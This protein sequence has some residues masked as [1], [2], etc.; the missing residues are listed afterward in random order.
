MI[1]LAGIRDQSLAS[2]GLEGRQLADFAREYYAD[3]VGGRSYAVPDDLEHVLSVG[4]ATPAE[5]RGIR[6]ALFAENILAVA[7]AIGE[8]F[9]GLYERWKYSPDYT[10]TNY[11]LNGPPEGGGQASYP[12]ILDALVELLASAD[13]LHGY[14]GGKGALDGEQGFSR[15]GIMAV[16]ID[17]ADA[18]NDLFLTGVS[19]GLME[20]VHDII[21]DRP[22]TQEAAARFLDALPEY[23]QDRRMSLE[24]FLRHYRLGQ[25]IRWRDEGIYSPLLQRYLRRHGS[26]WRGAFLSAAGGPLAQRVDSLDRALGYRRPPVLPEE[27]LQFLESLEKNGGIAPLLAWADEGSD[28]VD[29]FTALHLEQFGAKNALVVRE[30]L[31][32]GREGIRQYLGALRVHIPDASAVYDWEE[33]LADVCR[34]LEPNDFGKNE[35]LAA[36]LYERLRGRFDRDFRQDPAMA[37]QAIA[38]EIA[39]SEAP[40]YR[41]LLEKVHAHYV[42]RQRVRNVQGIVPFLRVRRG[43]ARR[44]SHP[45]GSGGPAKD[46]GTTR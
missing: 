2:L 44:T 19:P 16:L 9:A 4:D 25:D 45:S 38:G 8:S 42:L 15:M 37:L 40:I 1:S 27:E 43:E 26:G 36:I 30:L 23:R 3:Y 39:A 29:L 24:S 31:K 28:A 14:V 34:N 18:V 32:R 6:T 35:A 21:Y 20:R 12:G 33:H 13:A 11:L 41:S 7:P 17:N 5:K 10:L 46:A 22:L